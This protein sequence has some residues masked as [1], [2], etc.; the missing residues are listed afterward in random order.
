MTNTAIVASPE[1]TGNIGSCKSERITVTKERNGFFTMKRQDIVTNSCTG[2]VI[3]YDEYWVYS[4]AGG[5]VF[6][7][8]VLV[9]IAF[10]F[11]VLAIILD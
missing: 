10:G 1:I 11:I 4:E 7:A 2:E 9:G 6:G 5:S 8:I 3:N